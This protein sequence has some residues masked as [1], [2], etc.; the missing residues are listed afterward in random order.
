MVERR[1]RQRWWYARY[2]Q[3]ADDDADDEHD[4]RWWMRRRWMWELGRRTLWR[5]FL[6]CTILVC[7]KS[8]KFDKQMDD[9]IDSKCCQKFVVWVPWLTLGRLWANFRTLRTVHHFVQKFL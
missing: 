8:R 3:R 4:G 9:Y 6:L 5:Q 7:C 2:G 1:W